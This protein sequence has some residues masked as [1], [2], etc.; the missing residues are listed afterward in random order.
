MAKI[1]GC[2]FDCASPGEMDQVLDNGVD[3]SRIIFANP[4]KTTA[5]LEHALSGA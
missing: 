2:G 3:S 1:S 5:A 4:C